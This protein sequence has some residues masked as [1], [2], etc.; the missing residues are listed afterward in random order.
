MIKPNFGIMS[1]TVLRY[2]NCSYFFRAIGSSYLN[3]LLLQDTQW[4][5]ID[6]MRS[7]LDW[8]YDSTGQF[9]GLPAVVNDVHAHG[10][11]YVLI[12]VST[13]LS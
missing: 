5:D 2:L 4:D 11:H 9:A 10:Q 7:H 1:A 13:N 6:Y 3:N 8:T 12:I